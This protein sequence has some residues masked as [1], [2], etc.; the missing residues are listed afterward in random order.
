MVLSSNQ[1]YLYAAQTF[2]EPSA[3]SLIPVSNPSNVKTVASTEGVITGNP[4][5][6]G[7][8]RD[9]RGNLYV[10][11]WAAGE[12]WKIDR[13]R[14]FCVLASGLGRPSALVFGHGR[15]GFRSG[16]LYTVG[17]NGELTEIRGAI[18]ATYPAG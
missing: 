12:I 15:R 11:A 1:R 17:F 3:I 2:A 5:F 14:R 6:D 18:R 13:K 8:T 7:L 4:V 16:R 10:A 9:N